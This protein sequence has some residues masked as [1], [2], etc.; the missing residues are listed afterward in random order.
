[1]SMSDAFQWHGR[2]TY[3]LAYGA[4]RRALSLDT[5]LSD[6]SG[7]SLRPTLVEARDSTRQ[8]LAV[9]MGADYVD[10]STLL[11][12]CYIGAMMRPVDAELPRCLMDA[13]ESFGLVDIDP[14]HN[15]IAIEALLVAFT[16]DKQLGGRDAFERFLCVSN[17]RMVSHEGDLLLE[18]VVELVEQYG[19][20]LPEGY[21]FATQHGGSL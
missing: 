8:S 5:A 3:T 6:T 18:S 13:V 12:A 11:A 9:A 20:E 10:V 1:M 15:R 2:R 16:M 17:R 14:R 4:M 19:V 7:G 21:G